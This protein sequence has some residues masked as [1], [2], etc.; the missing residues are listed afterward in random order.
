MKKVV[1]SFVSAAA[2]ATVGMAA[3]SNSMAASQQHFSNTAGN[4][5]GVI[6]SGNLGYGKVD[7]RHSGIASKNLS[8]FAWNGSLGYQF[9][10]YFALESG[11]TGFHQI[12]VGTQKINTYGVDLLAKG[13]YPISNQFNVFAKVGA[14]D[15]FSKR[16]TNGVVGSKVSRIV[17]EFG[18]GTGYNLTH[19][20]ALTVQGI[21]TLSTKSHNYRMPSVYAAFA[22]LSYKFN[23]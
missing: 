21:A 20:L 15:L 18:I 22:G 12:K 16:L 23:V 13:I 6:I 19:N 10:R 5:A 17:P 14:M 7:F 9:N 3:A 2:L 1:V 8:G 11:Y 4:A